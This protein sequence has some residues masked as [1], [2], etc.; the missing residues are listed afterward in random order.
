MPGMGM[1]T[2]RSSMG[3]LGQR[4]GTLGSGMGTSRLGWGHQDWNEDTRK[5]DKD[6]RSG[7][8]TGGMGTPG[9]GWGHQ[10][11][12]SHPQ[13]LQLAIRVLVLFR[14]HQQLRDGF[15][16]P[17]VLVTFLLY[18]DTVGSHIQVIPWNPHLSIHRCFCP[19]QCHPLPSPQVLL[20]GFNEFLNNAAAGQKIWEYLDRKPT[21]DVGG[22]REPPELQGHVTFQK[23]SFAYPG[24]PEHP[25]L[26]VGLGGGGVSQGWEFWHHSTGHVL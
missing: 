25:V 12:C 1:V 19:S 2:F 9:V 6:T 26:K 3:T 18:Q 14:S 24:N 23:V 11:P 13:V 7:M 22:T 5:R 15:I 20:Y 4:L 10:Y 17:G 21:G 8:G 16:T